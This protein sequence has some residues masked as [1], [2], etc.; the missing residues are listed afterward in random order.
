MSE[1]PRDSE[2]SQA[3]FYKRRAL[4]AVIA[5]S[6]LAGGAKAVEEFGENTHNPESSVTKE[7]LH[8]GDEID[9]ISGTIVI[10]NGINRDSAPYVAG[11]QESTKLYSDQEEYVS[12]AIEID[13]PDDINAKHWISYL[14][15]EGRMVFVAETQSALSEIKLDSSPTSLSLYDARNKPGT[16]IKTIV[17]S[18]NSKS[19]TAAPNDL[20]EP[21]QIAVVEDRN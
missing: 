17:R 19:I 15:A 20:V 16:I 7:A 14:N 11:G 3:T 13:T 2:T 12:N 8:V 5:L 4:V 6:T 9:I 1:T 21:V 18:V 10:P